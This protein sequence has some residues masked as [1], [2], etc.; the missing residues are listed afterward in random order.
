MSDEEEFARELAL[1]LSSDADRLKGEADR[2]YEDWRRVNRQ[3]VV[4]ELGAESAWERVRLMRCE[5]LGI[6]P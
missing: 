2:L 6:E 5:R 1:A 3:A 4:A